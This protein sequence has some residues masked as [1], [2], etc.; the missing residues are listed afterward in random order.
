MKTGCSIWKLPLELFARLYQQNISVKALLQHWW[1]LQTYLLLRNQTPTMMEMPKR[2]QQATETR[3]NPLQHPLSEVCI[4]WKATL[5]CC[6]SSISDSFILVKKNGHVTGELLDVPSSIDDFIST[7]RHM[8]LS[9]PAL[10]LIFLI[11]TTFKVH[12]EQKI[13]LYNAR[14]ARLRAVNHIS[15]A[16]DVFFVVEDDDFILPRSWKWTCWAE[17]KRDGFCAG[18]G[19][20]NLR[21]IGSHVRMH[22]A[23]IAHM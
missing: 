11:R 19:S 18:A 23:L 5:S 14:G 6:S 8:R 16:I 1:S 10:G 22:G 13:R 9:F 20:A 12:A 17:E 2:A 21:W 3:K 15:P 7:I 4:D